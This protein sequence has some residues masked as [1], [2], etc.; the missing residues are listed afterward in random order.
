MLRRGP[1]RST[2]SRS[3]RILH[4][5]FLRHLYRP[6]IEVLESRRLLATFQV[7]IAEF[8]TGAPAA[9]GT[10]V[11]VQES[12]GIGALTQEATIVG[13]SASLDLPFSQL[14]TT[15]TC[16]YSVT[17]KSAPADWLLR[18]NSSTWQ[19]VVSKS[20]SIP[21]T[22]ECD[23]CSLRVEGYQALTD[24][25]GSVFQDN[26]ANGVEDNSDGFQAGLDVEIASVQTVPPRFDGSSPNKLGT[27]DLFGIVEI[28]GANLLGGGRVLLPDMSQAG[29]KILPTTDT[30]FTHTSS[31]V[32]T[33]EVGVF[34]LDISG[35]VFN[36]HNGDGTR[37]EE[38]ES[39]SNYLVY[40]DADADHILD[41]GFGC[42]V[43]LEACGTSD[44]GGNFQLDGQMKIPIG[45]EGVEIRAFGPTASLQTSALGQFTISSPY[46]QVVDVGMFEAVTVQGNVFHDLNGNGV[47]D[48]GEGGIPNVA[49]GLDGLAFAFTDEAGD[50]TMQFAGPGT[51][52]VLGGDFTV[53]MG[54]D[55]Y[56]TRSGEDLSG[57][58][59]GLFSNATLGGLAYRDLN[60]DGMRQHQH[61]P[62]LPGTQVHLDLHAD[63][64]IDRTT[65][66]DALGFYWFDSV[67]PGQHRV[68]PNLEGDDQLT[69]PA[70]GTGY[71]VTMQSA[72]SN[73][74]LDFGIFKSV[75]VNTTVD[76]P[77]T[78]PNDGVCDTGDR[79]DGQPECSLRA[80]IQTTNASSELN[81]IS[82][83]IPGVGPHRISPTASL[84]PI[85]Q[86]TIIKGYSQPGAAMA[87]D[88]L[89]ADL[90]IE[91]D[92]RQTSGNGLTIHGDDSS[93]S[94]L[95]IFGFDG[96]AIELNGGNRHVVSGNQL[97]FDPDVCPSCIGNG[98]GLR[99]VDSSENEVG[100]TAPAQQNVIAHNLGPG[101]SQESGVASALIRN[102]IYG[103]LGIGIDLGG[104][105][106][107]P[108]DLFDVDNG[109][110]NLQNFPTINLRLRDQDFTWVTGSMVGIPGTTY[111]ID[112]FATDTSSAVALESGLQGGRFL[113]S[114]VVEVGPQG[115][116]YFE[117]D[118]LPPIDES[119]VL[120]AMAMDP[121]GNSSEFSHFTP[122]FVAGDQQIRTPVLVV[123]GFF[124]SLGTGRD[125]DE[126]VRS[127]GPR[128]NILQMEPVGLGYE[129]L[130]TSLQ[131]AGYELNERDSNGDVMDKPRI[132]LWT[133]PYDW[134]LPL[135]PA[136]IPGSEL[137]DQADGLIDGVSGQSGF[138]IN[139]TDETFSYGIDYIG[140][141]LKQVAEK[142]HS[143]HGQPL[144]N[145]H[146]VSHSMGGL[147]SRSYIQ[148]SAYGDRF[149]SSLPNTPSELS[150]P[151]VQSLTMFGVPNQGS[152][153]VFPAWFDDFSSDISYELVLSKLIL[154]GYQKFLRGEE[155]RVV[156]RGV[157]RLL[158][159]S[160]FAGLSEYEAKVK[161]ARL[162]IP[163]MR[164]LQP[165]YADVIVNT[166]YPEESI[167]T[168]LHDL[169]SRN[170]DGVTRL[171]SLV[172]ATNAL[173]GV[174]N[175]TAVSIEERHGPSYKEIYFPDGEEGFVAEK[176]ISPFDAVTGRAPRVGEVWYEDLKD[177]AGGD[178]TVPNKSLNGLFNLD[179]S[180]T[181]FAFCSNNCDAIFPDV[182][183]PVRTTE[184]GVA[185]TQLPY[186]R[187]AQQI[188]LE[189]LNH[190]L[191]RESISTG[192]ARWTITA[193][194]SIPLFNG[195][196]FLS[197]LIDPVD[198]YIEDANGARLGF[199]EGDGQLAEIPESFYIGGA[200]GLG[201]LALPNNATNYPLT[202][203]IDGKDD[204]YFVEVTYF[205]GQETTQ[206][207][208]EG[209]LQR[210]ASVEIPITTSPTT[211][212][213]DIDGDQFSDPLTD[214]VLIKRFLDGVRGSALVQDA[215]SSEGDRL[216][217][218]AIEAYFS[219]LPASLF[220]IDDNDL[221]ESETDGELI[222]RA[223]AGFRGDALVDGVVDPSGG[224]T[225]I[226]DIE[227]YLTNQ[228]LVGA[229]ILPHEGVQRQR[230]LNDYDGVAVAPNLSSSIHL[231]FV[232]DEGPA[233][234]TGL[235]FRLHF[236]SRQLVMQGLDNVAPNGFSQQQIKDDDFDH[237]NDIRTDKYIVVQWS[238]AIGDWIPGATEPV[239]L[240]HINVQ[241]VNQF[242]GST[243]RFTAA[244][245]SPGFKL[246][247]PPLTIPST[248]GFET[249]WQNPIQP[250]DVNYDNFVSP[251]D[252]LLVINFLNSDRDSQL[253]S[254]S[255]IDALPPY[256]D[257][258]GDG[259]VSPIDA[260]Q[261][262]N[263]LNRPEGEGE[264]GLDRSSATPFAGG[265][266]FYWPDDD[267][268]YLV[269]SH[270]RLGRS[271]LEFVVERELD[272][273]NPNLEWSQWPW[274][275][276][277]ALDVALPS[278]ATAQDSERATS[279]GFAW[280]EDELRLLAEDILRAK[281]AARV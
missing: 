186:N 241:A 107:S 205:N 244:D 44:A 104:D 125:Y 262:I 144:A 218:T 277:Q 112:Y 176:S 138:G 169:N 253:P 80:A 257:P 4:S 94:G 271:D 76:L 42:S 40:L 131:T 130:V 15:R 171:G 38:D 33:F 242:V 121:F 181:Q 87:T 139:I 29:F 47:E 266:A 237:D 147:L 97:G 160:E 114:Q 275:N 28:E 259:F 206:T 187:D 189:R 278:D 69:Q 208:Q 258:S 225:D 207:I 109:A 195:Y 213:G 7:E 19:R 79:I 172:G 118:E 26:N 254:R 214:G 263:F 230:L 90:R 166:S 93:I 108:S 101:I 18:T 141:W 103:N 246:D 123:P 168:F 145:V 211:Y 193:A 95:A 269:Y 245:L 240:A 81:E 24:V 248:L 91:I 203:H 20:F 212:A 175:T 48:A 10:V 133:A 75:V 129:D 57:A 50:Y 92:G 163:G 153:V 16:A 182:V 105:G 154:H 192:E 56:S 159:P 34:G 151:M 45:A 135:A 140:F 210:G 260:L 3:S 71:I 221:V 61:D 35:Q 198:A 252:A 115:S 216:S 77:D 167:P 82:F 134:R 89:D 54:N 235:V 150:L 74:E 66:V 143:V 233:S 73:L 36:D 117:N 227:Q 142:W 231:Q 120:T 137:D 267:A 226:R 136:S 156:D 86:A 215:V 12:T 9:N 239:D 164:D 224:R 23:D 268:S 116:T 132:D 41:G 39:L 255:L 96:A 126:F 68:F 220:D 152:P 2:N 70:V 236:D 209:F 128:P 22:G 228:I 53:T 49:I 274:L 51:V 98:V 270:A 273:N 180:V 155:V 183:A 17:L 122:D 179:E 196:S 43:A 8:G 119:D 21:A 111:T 251:I 222:Q 261:I 52:E 46:R 72:I 13:G 83:S 85:T 280:N 158:V 243:I 174:D 223:M 113:G 110:N 148:S 59:L 173:Y 11:S 201:F 65:L 272:S 247:A 281:A 232:A 264:F 265:R 178:G 165:S 190:P 276:D 25:I 64:T 199:T 229:R 217:A 1:R 6:A 177:P 200:D 102:A 62:M 55:A 194:A 31:Q 249:S 279:N 14:C 100:G 149:E 157:S 60:R 67:G 197:I 219:A 37:D 32:A 162:Y 88:E 146:I 185:H 191:P 188:V 238:E 30:T 204:D 234:G 58:D 78:S 5:P 161:F 63:G 184:D 170:S 202:L 106:V 127:H 99:I 250:F 124:A 27:T 84:P 256:F